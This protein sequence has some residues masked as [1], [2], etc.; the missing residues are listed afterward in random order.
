MGKAGGLIRKALYRTLPLGGY[1]KVLS[2]AY[3]FC[4]RTGLMRRAPA[5]EYPRFLR[6]LVSEGDTVID[7]GANLGYYSYVFSRLVGPS[8]HV[9][10]VEPVRPILDVLRHNLRRCGNVDLYECALGAEERTIRMGNASVSES[11]YFGTGRN[12]V[13]DKPLSGMTMLEFEA[14]MKRGSRLF[15][16]LP[17]IDAIKCDIEGY[18]RIVMAD[19]RPLI[20]KHRPVVLIETDGDNRSFIVDLFVSM[21]YAG[22]T[23]ADGA[24][25]PLS[26]ADR[27]DIIFVHAS[28]TELYS[29]YIR[30]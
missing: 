8:G 13:M 3:L 17:R 30:A 28:K 23:L 18:E 1:L 22:Y 5:F 24:M 9:H 12:F 27:K 29:K 16:D 14:E 7:I 21:G 10:A 15:A 4:Y 25:K 20:E 6:N 2:G 19:M 26:A 11:G